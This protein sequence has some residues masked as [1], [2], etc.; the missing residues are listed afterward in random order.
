MLKST[1]LMLLTILGLCAA[2]RPAAACITPTQTNE[3]HKVKTL[4]DVGGSTF[5][6]SLHVKGGLWSARDLRELM[7]PF[8]AEGMIPSD[9]ATVSGGGDADINFFGKEFTLVD[10][11]ANATRADGSYSKKFSID[12]A[13]IDLYS[14]SNTLTSTMKNIGPFTAPFY[15]AVASYGV[16]TARGTISGEVGMRARGAAASSGIDVE[17]RAWAALVLEGSAGVSVGVAGIGLLG[18]VDL[19]EVG[20]NF[21][22]K[23]GLS[24]GTY[25]FENSYDATTL[26]GRLAVKASVLG[27][28]STLWENSWNGTTLATT[29]LYNA[30][31]CV[32]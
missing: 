11:E 12:V 29:T 21:K 18:Q 19:L 16:A 31:G 22:D 2:A 1:P 3:Y 17:G 28:S 15:T 14:G 5:G 30:S 24:S 23:T 4:F 27:A 7:A 13:G 10:L 26:D 9:Y 6:A 32:N 25:T 20:V 8:H